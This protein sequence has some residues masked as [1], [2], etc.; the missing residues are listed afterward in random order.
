M[1]FPFKSN[2][3]GRHF[4][5]TKV[6]LPPI[7]SAEVPTELTFECV[8]VGSGHAGSCAA[9]S[10]RDGGCSRVLIVDKCP[11][12]WVGG[13]GFF[14]AGAHRTVHGGLADLLPLV[15]NVPPE[16]ADT[17]DMEPYTAE[18]F[19]KDINR[20][21][22]DRADPALVKAVVDGSREAVGWLAERVKVPF[23]FSFNRQAYLVNGRQVFWGGMVLGVE[24]GGKGLIAA[25][26][27]AL[28]AAS[29][30]TWFNTAAEEI[31]LKNGEVAGLIVSQD[32]QKKTLRTPAVILAC[33]GFEASRSL[34]AQHLGEDWSRAMVSMHVHTRPR[35]L[36]SIYIILI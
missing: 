36:H 27:A 18:D 8:V 1:V 9:L 20:L 7:M 12:E 14:T 21:G 33:G 30:E 22:N 17:I 3:P 24:E 28:E 16:I 6:C 34:R 31:V 15:R 26:R 4:R 10:A 13:N 2:N 19:T 25:H 29:V 11:P 35:P 23:T 5:N 32:G